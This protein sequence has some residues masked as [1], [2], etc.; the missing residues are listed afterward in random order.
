MRIGILAGEASGDILGAGL[1]RALRQHSPEAIEFEGIGGPLMQA[2]GMDSRFP[3]ERLSVMGLVEVLGRLRELLGIRKQLRQHWLDNPPDLF[4]GID[5]PDFNLPLERSLKQ[6]SI[7]TVHYVSPS[8]WAWR[9]GRVKKIARAVDLVLCLLPFEKAF[10]DRSG[11]DALFVGHTLADQLPIEPDVGQARQQLGLDA[12]GRYIALLP[13]SRAGEVERLAPLFIE[14]ARDCLQRRSDLK[15]LIPTANDDRYQQL[16]GLLQD[17]DL[18]VQLIRGQSREVMTAADAVLLAS[19]TAA[20]ECM[21]LKTPMVV[22]YRLT[23]LSF[24]ILSRMIKVDYV[25]LPNL[26]ADRMLVPEL[27]QDD[28]TPQALT[29]AL[30]EQLDHPEQQVKHFTELHQ[31]LRRDASDQSAKAVLALLKQRQGDVSEAV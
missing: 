7:P 16:D 10:Y 14:T 17:Q 18:P 24:F 19:G 5:A 28:A 15:F 27:L 29:D 3:M 1:M 13:G 31:Q 22:S 8:I 20:L 21:L 25:S 9:Q 2:E 6:A 12:D 26:L 11:V 30:L 4:I 23:T